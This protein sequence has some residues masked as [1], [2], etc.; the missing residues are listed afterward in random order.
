MRI[1]I[2]GVPRGG[3]T[4]L[5]LHLAAQHGYPV[6]HADDFI[7]MG[8][9]EASAHVA[10]RLVSPGPYIVE[11]VSV[12]RALRKAME[13]GPDRPCD[14]LHWLGIPREDLRPK[15][16]SMGAADEKRFGE[17]RAELESRGV[18]IVL[19]VGSA[20]PRPARPAVA[21]PSASPP[22]PVAA[23]PASSSIPVNTG[24]R[25][26]NTPGRGFG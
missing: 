9:S 19:G 3:K 7:S 26:W 20:L 12:V 17:M 14:V 8:W 4:T 22:T 2:A 6:V 1:A 21:P 23:A 18:R 13:F 16:N 25:W 10:R 15:Q 5:A 11:G 24:S